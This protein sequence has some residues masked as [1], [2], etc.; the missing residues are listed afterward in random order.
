MN[1]RLLDQEVQ[2]FLEKYYKQDAGEIALKGSPFPQISSQELATQLA[3][4]KKAVKK[5]ANWFNTRGIIYPPVLNLEQ[6]SSDVTARYKATLVGGARL[7][8]LTGGFGVDSYYFSQKVDQV[9]HLEKDE[10]LSQVAAHNLGLLGASNISF[11]SGDS[12]EFLREHPGHF[13]W[14][15]VDPSRRSE[16]GGRVFRL[17]DCVPNVVEELDLLQSKSR[18]LLIKTAPLLDIQSGLREL[19]QVQEIHIVAVGNEVKELLWV[20]GDTTEPVQVTTVNITSRNIQ[21]FKAPLEQTQEA[22]SGN[23]SRYLYEPNAAIMKSG[24]FG[25][26]AR[27]Y[28]LKKLHPNSHLFTSQE[29]MEFPGRRFVIKEQLPYKRKQMKKAFGGTKANISTRNFPFDVAS[30][31]KE[32]KIKDGGDSYL[33]FTTLSQEERVVLVCEKV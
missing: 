24:L 20:L 15:Y 5:L 8:D 16:L 21:Q 13:D 7:A 2:E 33:F 12:L 23:P 11:I 27:Q 10:S 1:K 22:A 9:Y 3:G 32:L 25:S 30:L 4:K 28:Q 26:L 31:R 17:E 29:L 18:N 6:T 14:I 19:S